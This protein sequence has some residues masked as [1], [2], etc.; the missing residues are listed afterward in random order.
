[1]NKNNNMFSHRDYLSLYLYTSDIKYGT[2]YEKRIKRKIDAPI[3]FYTVVF[4]NPP[5][6]ESLIV[7]LVSLNRDPKIWNMEPI[8]GIICKNPP[9]GSLL[10]YG[11]CATTLG[12]I[13]KLAAYPSE[14]AF[15]FINDIF[16]NKID[17]KN[18]IMPVDPPLKHSK[19]I[20]IKGDVKK[21]VAKI[22]TRFP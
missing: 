22:K 8:E 14:N 17:K 19:W 6:E 18:N 7:A 16:L 15:K 11:A 4:K 10:K 5:N 3:V 12:T 1:M 21:I 20:Q 2:Q 9:E 13:K